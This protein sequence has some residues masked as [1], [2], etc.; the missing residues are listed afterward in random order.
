MLKCF[1]LLISKNNNIQIL[2]IKFRFDIPVKEIPVN[3][4][5]IEDSKLNVVTASLSFFRDYF[6][7]IIFYISGFW[8]LVN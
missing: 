5:E 6:A 2:N 4:R 1:L 3:W 7:I 8:Q